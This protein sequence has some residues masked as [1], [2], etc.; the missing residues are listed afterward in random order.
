MV[1]YRAKFNKFAGFKGSPE[2][3]WKGN[4]AWTSDGMTEVTFLAY[5]RGIR[6]L[7]KRDEEQ[8]IESLNVI[9]HTCILGCTD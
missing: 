7:K 5:P 9:T 6:R 3:E 4:D 8:A 2:E 1:I